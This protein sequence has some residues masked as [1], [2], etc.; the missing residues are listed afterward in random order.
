MLG[1]LERA[2]STRPL[3][4]KEYLAAMFERIA[5]SGVCSGTYGD[6]FGIYSSTPAAPLVSTIVRLVWEINGFFNQH[7]S[8][9][10]IR[11]TVLVNMFSE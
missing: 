3:P 1:R 5:Y 6:L 7:L 8:L 10:H 2:V 11:N 9:E 4:F